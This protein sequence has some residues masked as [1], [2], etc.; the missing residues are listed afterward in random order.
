M[1]ILSRRRFLAR[2]GAAGL[3][4]PL[5]SRAGGTL[6]IDEPIEDTPPDLDDSAL[7]RIFADFS[8]PLEGDYV[9]KGLD[10]Y[11]PYWW[12]R[13][14]LEMALWPADAKTIDYAHL[15]EREEGESF[16]LN[17]AA[18]RRIVTSH[19]YSPRVSGH[20]Y[21]LFGIRGARRADNS[22]SSPKYENAIE[23]TE[24]RPNHFDHKCLLGVWNTRNRKVWAATA[25]TAPHVAYLF[26]QRAASTYDYEANM[27]PTGLYRYIVGTHRNFSSSFQP[28]AFRPD[29][30]AFAVL[31]CVDEGPMIMSSDQ[32]WDTRLRNHGDNIHAGT[33]SSSQNG[34]KFFSAGCQVMPGYYSEER[35]KPQGDWARFRIAAGLERMPFVTQ[36]ETDHGIDVR[37][38]EDGR[39]YSYILTTGRD[40]LLAGENR[41]PSTLRF[42]SSGRKVKDLQTALGISTSNQDGFFGIG[43]QSK[44]LAS[45]QT[46]TPIVDKRL[47]ATLE[48]DL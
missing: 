23:L 17:D 7:S 2:L 4:G 48:F 27:M 18:L 24:V 47:A 40:V 19:A 11:L 42:G 43:V 45:G 39:K 21:I 44:L 15:P 25:S 31:R 3:A 16:V 41:S 29:N 5:I 13:L 10:D 20:P 34:P 37:T 28:G 1:H 35:T 14:P 30:R 6:D 26:I 36:Q 9:V 33:P 32:F 46:K 38:S 22:L 8:E 12:K